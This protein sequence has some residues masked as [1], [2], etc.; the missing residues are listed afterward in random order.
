MVSEKYGLFEKINVNSR[1]EASWN[2]ASWNSQKSP[3]VVLLV[4]F[5]EMADTFFWLYATWHCNVLTLG[6]EEVIFFRF[7]PV[8]QWR[9]QKIKSSA[10]RLSTSK[11]SNDPNDCEVFVM[12]ICNYCSNEI[13]NWLLSICA[14]STCQD[15]DIQTKYNFMSPNRHHFI[16]ITEEEKIIM[17]FY[18]F[19]QRTNQ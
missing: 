10:C 1:L 16:H 13:F 18:Y 17:N 3:A 19:Q 15:L 11:D 9:L 2:T 6:E 7:V 12:S 5:R 8:F 4:Y 14:H